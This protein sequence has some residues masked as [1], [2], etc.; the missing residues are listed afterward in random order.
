[1][2]HTKHGVTEVEQEAYIMQL[3]T[4]LH[5]LLGV[6]KDSIA[7]CVDFVVNISIFEN[8][9]NLCGSVKFGVVVCQSSILNCEVIFMEDLWPTLVKETKKYQRELNKVALATINW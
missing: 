1:M 8:V 4:T 3:L 2:A 9:A 6:A 5:A 7:T